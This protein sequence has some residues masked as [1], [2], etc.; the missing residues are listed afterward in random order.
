[1]I[2]H[3]NSYK[4]F[5][6]NIIKYSFLNSLNWVYLNIQRVNVKN[7][8]LEIEIQFHI[9]GHLAEYGMLMIL[10]NDETLYNINTCNIILNSYYYNYRNKKII[11]LVYFVFILGEKKTN[12]SF[13]KFQ[14]TMVTDV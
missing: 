9:L 8:V 6:G 11:P 7:H 13:L 4:Y 14:R 2:L 3:N 1:M 10:H 12:M 5:V